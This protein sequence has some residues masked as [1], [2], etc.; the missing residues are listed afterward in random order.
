MSFPYHD[1]AWVEVGDFLEGRVRPGERVLAPDLFW[2]RIPRSIDRW[3]TQNLHDGNSYDWVV[4]HK[5]EIAQFPRRFLEHV[6]STTR[7]VFANDVFVVWSTD[8][9]LDVVDPASPHLLTFVVGVAKL[10]AT[11]A[12]DNH[13]ERDRTVADSPT[14]ERYPDLAPT[15]MRNAENEF[16][17]A[18]GYQYVTAR[19]RGYFAD[20]QA[21]F[22]QA[23]E[24][25]RGSRVLDLACGQYGIDPPPGTRL[26][27]VDF[28]EEC[29][30]RT[31]VA[32]RD[33][34]CSHLVMD[35]HHLGFPSDSFDAVGLVDASEHVRDIEAVV[36]E[37]SRVLRPGGELLITFANRNSLHQ[38][39]TRKLGYPEFVTNHHHIREF[40]G[41][42]MVAVLA[43]GGFEVVDTAGV[44]FFPYWGVP[45]LDDAVR[46]ITDGDD[47]VVEA[48]R[49]IGR[50]VGIDYAYVGVVLARKR[51]QTS[52]GSP[53][54]S[55]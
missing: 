24:R 39:V 53:N 34:A 41:D 26:I 50:R 16:F 38:L 15:E 4:V 21:H 9:E 27:R 45:G 20:I 36:R 12:V 51:D 54:R 25:W 30:R 43:K 10:P 7:P 6:A 23:L 19:D 8:P 11:P 3:V 42:E 47:E 33:H 1:R 14:L 32:D 22:V 40:D 18:G 44:D 13:Y 2:W 17:R 28:A 37:I 5:G 48:M 52:S 49:E 55:V 29:I 31:V 35:A 46:A